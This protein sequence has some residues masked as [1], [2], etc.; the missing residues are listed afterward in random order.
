LVATLPDRLQA[1]TGALLQDKS[2]YISFQSRETSLS[3]QLSQL[4][5]KMSVL[6]QQ[7]IEVKRLE[8]RVKVVGTNY[9]TY[10]ASLEE[11]RVDQ[12]FQEAQI[13]NISIVQPATL[14]RKAA[15]PKKGLTLAFALVVATVGGLALPLLSSQLDQS[16]KSREEVECWLNAPLLVSIPYTNPNSMTMQQIL[17]GARRQSDHARPP[18]PVVQG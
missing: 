7:E 1:M 16:L 15:S 13:T 9:L 14:V 5:D 4:H 3:K 8:L 11:T 10:A 12:A 17:S 2:E 18:A 6:N